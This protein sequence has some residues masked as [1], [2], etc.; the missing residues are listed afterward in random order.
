[1]ATE[2]GSESLDLSTMLHEGG[3]IA[4]LLLFWGILAALGRFGIGNI[5][6]AR[7]GQLFFE[8]GNGLA[9]L[10]VIT[11]LASVLLYV[12]A[13]GIHL[14]GRSAGSPLHSTTLRAALRRCQSR[15]GTVCRCFRAQHIYHGSDCA[16]SY[17]EP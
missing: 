2:A 13:R 5:G 16:M 3:R 7:P 1:M 4:A 9:L 11:G 14:S 17:H 12:I 15:G 6:F 8:I 10:F